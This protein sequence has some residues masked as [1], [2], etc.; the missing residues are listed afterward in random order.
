MINRGTPISGNPHILP[1]RNSL[2]ALPSCPGPDQK[3]SA[4]RRSWRSVPSGTSSCPAGCHP[5]SIAFRNVLKSG[6]ILWFMVDVT[7]LLME[8]IKQQTSLGGTILCRCAE[9]WLGCHSYLIFPTRTW[10]TSYQKQEE[11]SD[12]ILRNAFCRHAFNRIMCN[13][14][15]TSSLYPYTLKTDL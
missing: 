11:H 14:R 1:N 15:F 7:K 8:F 4:W 3:G 6:W 13:Y 9:L 12:S 5:L 2:A 10:Y